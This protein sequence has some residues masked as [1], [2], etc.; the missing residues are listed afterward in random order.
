MA[1]EQFNA[2]GGDS[3]PTMGQPG[4]NT[5]PTSIPQQQD[6]QGGTV[7]PGSHIGDEFAGFE[8]YFSFN[9][10]GRYVMPD[11]KQWIEFRR[12]TEGDRAKYLKATRSDVYLNQKTGD[13]RLTMDQGADRKELLLASCTNWFMVTKYGGQARPVPFQNNGK[14][15]PFAQWIDKANP[16]ILADLE[17]EI[18]KFNPW[19][20]AEMTIEQIDKEMENLAELKKAIEERELREKASGVK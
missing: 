6:I 12:M 8:D 18:R 15:S 7:Q 16:Q 3:H 9:E 19:L 2:G 5:L 1:V 10:T 11:G 13:A 20:M 17:K 4:V 14:G